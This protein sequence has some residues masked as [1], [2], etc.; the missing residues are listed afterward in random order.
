MKKCL[1][2]L[3]FANAAWS[4]CLAQQE[5]EWQKSFGGTDDDRASCIQQTADSGYII[6][7]YT[8]SNDGDVSVNHGTYDVWIVKLNNSGNMLWQKCYGGTDTE[9]AWSIQQTA[10]GGYIFTGGTRSNDG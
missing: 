8:R 7:G 4:T 2:A 5:I 6:V 9:S 3:C 1:L 10:D